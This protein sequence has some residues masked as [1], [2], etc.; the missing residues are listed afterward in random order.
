MLSQSLKLRWHPVA[1][2]LFPDA[3]PGRSPSLQAIGITAAPAFIGAPIGWR[4]GGGS[5]SRAGLCE[6]WRRLT[7]PPEH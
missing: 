5:L 1:V 7:T 3:G 2:S 6:L 4:L